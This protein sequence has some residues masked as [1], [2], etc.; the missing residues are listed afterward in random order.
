MSPCLVLPE[1]LKTQLLTEAAAAHPAE[2][3][4]LLEGVREGGVVRIT[5]LHPSNN[6]SPTPQTAFEIDPSL[7]FSLLR[8]LR[9][10][11]RAVVGCYHSH[12]N[13]RAEPSPRDRAQGWEEGFVWV[14]TATGVVAAYQAPDFSPLAIQDNNQE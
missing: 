6:L 3:C 13:G 4:G 2:C 9:G 10:S 11:G 5:A 1:A 8:G 7:Q 14:I 12:P